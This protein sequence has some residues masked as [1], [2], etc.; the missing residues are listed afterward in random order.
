[1]TKTLI[2]IPARLGSTRLSNKLIRKIHGREIIVWVAQRIST[3]G[4]DFVVAIDDIKVGE[5]LQNYEIPY[6]LTDKSH[7][8]GTSRVSQV[9][10][11]MPDFDYYCSVQGDEPLVNPSEVSKFIIGL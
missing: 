1:M 6:V 7:V 2:V 10:E 5:I 4:R 11:I 3:L 8:S 9:A